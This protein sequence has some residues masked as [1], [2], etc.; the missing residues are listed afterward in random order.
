MDG[1][2]RG[3]VDRDL[4]EHADAVS[5]PCGSVVPHQRV[6]L[7]SAAPRQCDRAVA[8]ADARHRLPRARERGHAGARAMKL[9]A[10]LFAL[11]TIGCPTG[12]GTDAS[13]IAIRHALSG[14]ER[15]RLVVRPSGPWAQR[16]GAVQ[17]HML[18]AP[19]QA[20]ATKLDALG[21]EG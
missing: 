13:P 19:E 6:P 18:S 8:L 16:Y 5:A 20:I 15:T 11:A 17:S 14:I 2:A 1:R 3:A 9:R 10:C 12:Q 7:R 4:C 21:L